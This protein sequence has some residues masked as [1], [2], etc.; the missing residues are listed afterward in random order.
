MLKYFKFLLVSIFMSSLAL[1]AATTNSETYPAFNLSDWPPDV[2][3]PLEKDFPELLKKQFTEE[4]LSD[5]VKKLHKEMNFEQLKVVKRNNELFLVATLTSKVEAI[6]F[7]GL[8]EID[9]EEATEIFALTNQEALDE[10]KVNSG[11]ERMTNYF[12]NIGYRRVQVTAHLQNKT[13]ATRELVVTIN[14][15]YKTTISDVKIEGLTLSDTKYVERDFAWNGKGKILSDSTLKEVNRSLRRSLNELGYYLVTTPSPQITFTADERKARLNFKLTPTPK[16]KI[17]IVGQNIYSEDFLGSE[18]LKLDDY[19]STDA[20][21]S[22]ELSEKIRVYFL[23]QGYAHAE[24]PAT[25]RKENDVTIITFHV[26]P[27][28]FVHIEKISVTG[29][30]SRPEEYYVKKFKSLS[31]SKIQNG[32]LIQEDVEQAAKNLITALQNEGFVNAKLSRLQVGTQNKQSNKALVSLQIEEGPQAT[33]EQ[34]NITGNHLFSTQQINDTLGLKPG[35]KLNLMDLEKAV[36]KL[37]VFYADNGFIESKILSE[38]KKLI[39]YS[40]NLTEAKIYIDIFE[41]PQIRAGSILVEGNDITHAKL[42]LTE[43]DFKVGE[44]LTPAKLEESIARLQRTGHFSSI[45]IYTLEANTDV[46]ERTVIVR[47]LERKPGLITSG[48]GFTNENQFTIQGYAGLAYRNLGG[49]G[50]GLSLRA[51]VKYN[52]LVYNFLE[53]RITVGY[54]EPYLLDTRV[55]FRLNYTSS[56][57]ITDFNT[58]KV[59]LTNQTIWSLE[60]DFNSH[61]TGIYEILDIS[62]YV[63]RGITP[64]DEITYSYP[65][66]DMVISTTG[67]TIDL[68]YRDNVLNPTKGTW[69]TITVEYSA[70]AIG[71]HNCD[72]FVRGTG[73]TT[74]YT[75][76]SEEKGIVWANSY[77]AGYV[78]EIGS[79]KYGIPFDKKGFILGGRTTVRG[80]DSN[81]FFPSTDINAHQITTDYRFSDFSWFQLIKSEFRF[82]LFNI[83]DLYGAVFYDGGEVLIDHV[84]LGDVYRDAAGIGVRYNTPVGPINLEYAQKLDRKSYESA[85]AFYLSVGVF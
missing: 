70:G 76:L 25:E 21:F 45:E 23:A 31:S 20:S 44:L 57:E 50:R 65:R 12:K 67:P 13:T 37:K 6:T 1:A 69:S 38:N 40:E 66:D 79:I 19:V 68:D 60:E 17:E 34:V 80:F 32:V 54:L 29:S 2:I 11:I 26:N 18:V 71:N 33:I 46:Q 56:R 82:P 55:R 52:P 4:E 43:L 77:H 41:G 74:L 61:L 30:L 83:S 59:T 9:G 22:S 75:L 5:L 51:D 7:I 78:K 81:E 35:D 63:D 48:L 3:L 62:N 8:K 10:N 49:W 53:D 36:N 73:Q 84:D 16:F 39:E 14:L 28:A 24:A 15:G 47:V 85:G 58:R 72:D 27:G 42:I 64:Q